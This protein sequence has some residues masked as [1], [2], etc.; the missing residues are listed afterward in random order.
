MADDTK[1]QVIIGAQIDELKAG[2]DEAAA[3]VQQTVSA[4]KDGFKGISAEAQ[5]HSAEVKGSFQGMSDALQNM[6]SSFQSG[7]SG[8]ASSFGNMLGPIGAIKAAILEVTAVFAGF[9]ALLASSINDQDAWVRDSLKLANGLGLTAQ[10]ASVLKVKLEE[11]AATNLTA[12]IS[13][14][15]LLRAVMMMESKIKSASPEI[16]KYNLAWKGTPF[17][18]FIELAR[19]YQELTSQTERMDMASD[20]FSKRLAVQLM[21]ILKN[22]GPIVDEDREKSESLGRV[23]GEDAVRASQNLSIAT[24]KM[25]EQWQTLHSHLATVAIPLWTDIK[26]VLVKIMEAINFVITSVGNLASSMA[27]AASKGITSFVTGLNNVLEKL[28][29]ISGYQGLMDRLV[30]TGVIASGH[31]PAVQPEEPE[32]P[33]PKKAPPGPPP[34]K[35][36]GGKGG[37]DASAVQQWQNELDQMKLAEKAYQDQSLTMEKAFWAD[38][39][40][41]G[42]TATKEQEDELKSREKAAATERLTLEKAFW[43]SKLDEC[44]TGTKE[45]IEV[46]HKIVA[47]EQ[48]INKSRLQSE[49]DLIKSKI[50]ANQQSI[51]DQE[52]LLDQE[53]KLAK[54]DLAMK[55]EDVNYLAQ[56]GKTTKAQE[57]TEYKALLAQEQALDLQDMQKRQELYSGDLVKYAEYTK[58]IEILKKQQQLDMKKVDDQISVASATTWSKMFD[59]MTSSM[60]SFM[61]SMFNSTQ[62]MLSS[63]GSLFQSLASSVANIFMQMATDQAKAA[64]FGTEAQVAASGVVVGAK[65]A[66]SGASGFASVMKALPWPANIAIAAAIAAAAFAA[67]KAFMPKASAAGGFWNV[68]EQMTTMLHPQEMVI[69]AGPAAGLRDLVTSGGSGG[70]GGITIHGPL[71]SANINHKMTQVEWHN[72]SDMMLRALNRALMRF[73]K[74]PLSPSFT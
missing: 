10:D 62:N 49:I 26:E 69:P 74:N 20:F 14:Q 28:K 51:K 47:L 21:P 29:S 56:L 12:D 32:L 55:K 13:T 31:V 24:L 53:Q 38:K 54:I 67:T 73:G 52:S 59:S 2:M 11:L 45:Y 72:Q 64:I 27:T 46:Q 17:D 3:K 68:P 34:P 61:G 39:L 40:N 70:G 63:I 60:N 44:D 1:A 33:M 65:A 6:S 37:G 4:M 18:T 9:T 57:L 35:A 41:T 71:I 19:R 5:I 7:A 22:L 16:V 43:T 58:K 66:E 42:K 23:V 30:A 25:H 15:T 36:G 48:N 8:I 50:A